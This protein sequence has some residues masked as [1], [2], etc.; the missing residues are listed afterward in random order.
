M[1]R[2]AVDTVVE[3]AIVSDLKALSIVWRSGRVYS[4]TVNYIKLILHAVVI[5]NLVTISD[6]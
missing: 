1:D 6:S 2:D 5:V 3:D 4:L